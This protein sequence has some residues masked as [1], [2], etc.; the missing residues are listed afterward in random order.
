MQIVHFYYDIKLLIIPC[1]LTI[2]STKLFNL[3][4]DIWFLRGGEIIAF[5]FCCLRHSFDITASSHIKISP[6]IIT[7]KIF[8]YFLFL[9]G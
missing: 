7:M 6:D 2:Y 3:D 5:G 9:L 1:P 8:I 4:M